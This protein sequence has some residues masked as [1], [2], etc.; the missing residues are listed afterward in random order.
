MQAVDPQARCKL[1]IEKRALLG[2]E[3]TRAADLAHGREWGWTHKHDE[4]CFE[5]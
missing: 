4:L 3:F 5:P 2:H 1:R